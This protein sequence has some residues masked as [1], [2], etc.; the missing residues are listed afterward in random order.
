MLEE[1][2]NYFASLP[3]DTRK[4]LKRIR[5]DI[6]AA[7]PDAVEHFSYRIPAFKLDGKSLVWYAAFKSHVSMFP[8][9]D[10]IRRKY[11]REL[12][13]LKTAKGT[14]QFPLATPPSSSLVRTLVK[15]RVA[16][17]RESR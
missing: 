10:A 7:A 6:R 14:I 15:A 2:R 4:I 9:G 1:V 3:P 11:A 12:H 17:V 13:G 8:M 5:E 16:E